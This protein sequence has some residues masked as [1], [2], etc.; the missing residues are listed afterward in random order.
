M[1]EQLA[2]RLRALEGTGLIRQAAREPEPEYA[3]RHALSLD[4]A[5]ESMLKLDRRRLHHDVGECLERFLME[6]LDEYAPILARH[7]DEA[8]DDARALTYYSR[9]AES[10]ARR[11]ANQEAITLL[12]RARAVALR[13]SAAGLVIGAISAKAGRLREMCGDYDGALKT[14]DALEAL[15][16]E[17]RDVEMKCQA[18]LARAAVF[19]APTTRF[20]AARGTREGR[21]A[22][23]LAVE[24]ADRASES[25]AFWLLLLGAKFSFDGAGALEAGEASAAI[26][27][28]LGLKEQ[29]AFTLNDLY[30]AYLISARGGRDTLARDRQPAPAGRY[31]DQPG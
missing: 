12:D 28:E 23:R 24:T 15:A 3:F 1:N 8:G 5:Y 19:C 16:D 21:D 18:I 30:P 10:A 25:K 11:Y 9:A 6:N 13:S 22:L 2:T 26:A 27:R 20:D 17:R 14:Y 7:F 29:L 4:A 31:A